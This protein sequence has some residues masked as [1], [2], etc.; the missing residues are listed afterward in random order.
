VYKHADL[1]IRKNPSRVARST[2]PLALEPRA[3][4]SGRGAFVLR[5]IA[6]PLGCGGLQACRIHLLGERIA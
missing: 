4:R 2:S 6:V 1:L 5:A 3:A